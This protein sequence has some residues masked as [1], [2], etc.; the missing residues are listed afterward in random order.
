MS[1]G[2]RRPSEAPT[3]AGLDADE[4]ATNQKA[5]PARWFIGD[6]WCPLTWL[7]PQPLNVEY[8]EQR[9]KVGKSKQTTGHEVFA[10][11]AGLACVGL[12]HSITAIEV[13]KEIVWTGSIV[14]PTDTEDPSYW[15][16]TIVTNVGTFYIYWGRADQPVDS[17]LLAPLGALDATQ[18]HPAY[19]NQCIVIAKR[20]SFGQSTSAPSIRVKLRRVPVPQIGTFAA[21]NHAQGES[22]LAGALELLTDPIFGASIAT[23]HFTA[24]DWEALSTAVIAGAGRHSPSLTRSQPVRDVVREFFRLFDGWARI[25]GGK[26]TPGFFP[27]DGTGLDDLPEISHHDIIGDPDIG[28]P[29]FSKAA[30]KVVVTFRDRTQKHRED[31]EKH[32]ARSNSR[33]RQRVQPVTVSAL[34]IIDR[35]QARSYAAELARG[36]AEGESKGSFTVR[37]PRAIKT[38]GDPLQAGD[39]FNLDWS[40]YELDQI[41]RITRISHPYRGAPSID[42]VAE[43]GIYP[44]PY[45]PPVSLQ[46]DLGAP[47]PTPIAHARILELTT[48]L[49][50]TPIGIQIAI[51]AQRPPGEHEDAA[52]VKAKNVAGFNLHYS[53]DD[54]TFDPIG[55]ASGWSVRANLVGAV[56]NTAAATTITIN[57]P[58]DNLDTDRITPISAE[59]QADDQLLLIIGDEVLSVGDVTLNAGNHDLTDCLRARQGS[60]KAAGADDAEVWL[61]YRDEL[62]RFAH[63]RFIEDTTRYFKPQPYSPGNVVDLADIDSITHAFRDRADELPVIALGAAPVSPVVGIGQNFTGSISDVNGD[64]TTYEITAARIV[65]AAIDSEIT[66]RSAEFGPDDRALFNFK[67]PVAFPQAGTWRIIVRAHDERTGFKETQTADITVSAGS[68]GY[69]TDDGVTPSAITGVSITGAL[70]MLIAEWTN[71]VNTP[72][73]RT[74]IYIAD[75]AAKPAN[76]SA[77]IEDPQQFYFLQGLD[78]ST[79]KYFWFEVVGRN[80]RKSAVSGPHNATTR[81]GIDLSDIVAGLT[82]VEIVGALPGTDLTDGRTVFLTTDKKLYRYDATAEEWTRKIDG[83]DLVA[84][85]IV[86]GAIAAG[87][88]TAEAVGANEIIANVANIQNGI[89]TSAKIANLDAE[90]VNTGTLATMVLTAS[91]TRTDSSFFN[92]GTPANTFP[93]FCA[94]RDTEATAGDKTVGN[95]NY[96]IL[97]VNGWSVGTGHATRFGKA[98]MTFT[99]SLKASFTITDRG[100]GNSHADARSVFR[101]NAGSWQTLSETDRATETDGGAA[102]TDSVEITGLTGSD[103]IDFGIQ[104]IVP[105]TQYYGNAVM[106][107]VFGNV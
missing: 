24:A 79:Q 41:S 50:G 74:L 101:I 103:V 13:A 100:A 65:A 91:K 18:S 25:E 70:S 35:D 2:Y 97:S 93:S 52:A 73:L 16:A 32:T 78:S 61:I 92:A 66:I 51:L 38:N 33:A 11:L 72:I 76:P 23:K 34:S 43:R 63:K 68:G 85:S 102:I 98:T 45:V 54:A 21:E 59:D 90:K 14:R 27:H 106:S 80:G 8:I 60:I 44:L 57:I 95:Y 30:N 31:T 10:D 71:P 81:A 42:Y 55:N 104:V 5:V 28:A 4:V 12:V 82:M 3:T 53:A 88:I 64:L 1:F 86:A 39:N 69:G 36:S 15:R 83:A 7:I 17:I 6:D 77:S 75:T 22:L 94:E 107:V 58:A 29:S 105:A 62:P 47:L 84:D 9:E 26:I 56:A 19:R 40:P 99:V 20:A 37:L 87:A 96:S 67:V 46:P 48:E 89:I 49:A